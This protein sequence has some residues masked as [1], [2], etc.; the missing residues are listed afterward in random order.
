MRKIMRIVKSGTLIRYRHAMG[1]MLAGISLTLLADHT[2][3]PSSVTVAGS[4]QSELGCPGDWQPDCAV[5]HLSFDVDD[6]VWQGVFAVPAG[7]WEYKAPLNDTWDENYGAGALQN[8]PNI[9]LNLGTASDVKFYYDHKTHWITDNINSVIA[10]VPGSFLSELGCPGDWQPDCLRSWLQ[11]P[12][13]DG[14]YSFTAVLP[15]G[16]YEA[17]VTI[18]ESWDENYG[19]GG[20]QNG[21]NIPFTVPGALAEMLFSFD[22]ASKILTISPAPPPAQPASV[23]VAGNLQDELGCP[24]DWQPD[25]ATTH[26]GFDAEDTVWQGVFA[27]PAGNWEYKAPLNDSWDENYGQNAARDG[28]NIPLSLGAPTDV[29]FYYE[30]GT[31]WITDNINSVI[32]TVAGSFQDELGC[33]GDWQPWCLRSWLQDPD[34]D[35][36]YAFSALLPAGD[37]E[38][39]VAHNEDWSENYGQGGIPGGANIPFTVPGPFADVFFTY[40]PATHILTIGSEAGGPVGNL[41]EA[42]AHWVSQDIIAWN[43]GSAD[44][45]FML[46]YAANGGM[47]LDETGVVGADGSLALTYDPAGLPAAVTDRFPHLASF[48]ALRLD[49]GDLAMV[50]DILKGQIA[51]A[52]ADSAG[53]PIDATGMQIPGVLDDL[54]TF[55][56]DLGVVFDGDAPTLKL[57]APTAKN[58]NLLVFDDADPATMPAPYPMIPDISTGVWSLSVSADW[59]GKYYLYDVSVYVPSTDQ[60][61]NNM[62]TDPYSLGLSMN[63]QRSQI[64]IG[65]AHV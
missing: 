46:Y 2:P 26:L 41:A 19:Q 56:G 27:V 3:A 7:A 49:A 1:V 31:H 11:D 28:A 43:A 52:A 25:C 42:T 23:T 40:D 22:V 53:N 16:D 8:G 39:K 33:S 20:V 54:Y 18:G 60:V 5:T 45:T 32:A 15:G 44:D 17:K 64:E 63:S 59:K 61:E 62:V 12:D 35:G 47:S 37:Y 6:D 55:A 13:G 38:A 34:G 21:A 58:V 51:L 30:H 65:R 29:K 9:P 4:L 24:G 14:V 10:T 50:P 57:W 48:A 36:I